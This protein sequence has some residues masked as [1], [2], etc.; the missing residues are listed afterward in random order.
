MARNL[1]GTGGLSLRYASVCLSAC[2]FKN[3]WHVKRSLLQLKN[4]QL[5]NHFPHSKGHTEK[6]KKK[7]TSVYLCVDGGR[8]PTLH[9][10]PRKLF[11]MGSTWSLKGPTCRYSS[12]YAPLPFTSDSIIKWGKCNNPSSTTI[13]VHRFLLMQAGAWKITMHRLGSGQET[14]EGRSQG[15]FSQLVCFY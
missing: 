7:S 4:E 15:S 2:G 11:V 6:K 3:S 14:H 10:Q 5:A 13:T 12:Q 8:Q 1:Q 9:L